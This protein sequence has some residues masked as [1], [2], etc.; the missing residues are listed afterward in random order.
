MMLNAA[1]D[2]K[3]K[4]A[5]KYLRHRC[6]TI[7]IV[8]FCLVTHGKT[9]KKNLKKK[10]RSKKFFRGLRKPTTITLF[11]VIFARSVGSMLTSRVRASA[12]RLSTGIITPRF[13]PTTIAVP[14]TLATRKVTSHVIRLNGAQTIA[15]FAQHDNGHKAKTTFSGPVFPTADSND[16]YP[17]GELYG[18]RSHFL[19][20]TDRNM[21]NSYCLYV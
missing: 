12:T 10:K 17:R 7:T 2:G 16:V 18:Q 19:L 6:S 13:C 11:S 1:C 20:S 8:V 3:D 21:L 4:C 15:P 9:K 5:S 14:T